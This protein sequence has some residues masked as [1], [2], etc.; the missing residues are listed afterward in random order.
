MNVD[1]AI[2]QSVYLHTWF[3]TSSWLSELNAVEK[4]CSSCLY[5]MK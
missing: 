5:G 4:K 3:S 2:P 1:S